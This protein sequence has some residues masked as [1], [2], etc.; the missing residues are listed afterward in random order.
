[1]SLFVWF[2]VLGGG[3]NTFC[4]IRRQRQKDPLKTIKIR[5]FLSATEIMPLTI[6]VTKSGNISVAIANQLPF[7]SA[8]DP[9]VLDI[10]YLSFRLAKRTFLFM[11]FQLI[12]S[13]DQT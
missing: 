3:G 11:V 7:L 5:R 13:F 10:K 6:R 4:E 8:H 1:M 12:H 2:L 9:H